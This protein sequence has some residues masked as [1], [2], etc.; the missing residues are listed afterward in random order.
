[1]LAVG[2][3]IFLSEIE[4]ET[5][6]LE[7]SISKTDRVKA[8][9]FFSISLLHSKLNLLLI[10]N[11]ISMK[12][13]YFYLMVLFIPVLFVCS[14][15]NNSNESDKNNA[16]QNVEKVNEFDLL[17]K[18]LGD[19][20]FIN[21]SKKEGGAPTMIKATQL[22]ELLESGANVL[23]LD[24]RNSFDYDAGHIKFAE[25]VAM[26]D[27]IDYA[28]EKDLNYYEKVVVVC[29]T[30]QSA[31]YATSVLRHLGYNNVYDLKWGMC[32]WGKKFAEKKWLANTSSKYEKDLV[33]DAAPKSAKGAYPIIETGKTNAD[34]ILE[35]QA[36]KLLA[37]GFGKA[38]IKVD[39]LFANL[40]KYY[41]INYWPEDKYKFA[42]IPGAIQYTPKK[43]LK[44][45]ADLS[46]LPTD[47]PIVVYCYTGQHASFVVAYLRILGYNARSL[48]YGANS[49]MNGI[50]KEKNWNAFTPEQIHEFSSKEIGSKTNTKDKKAVREQSGGC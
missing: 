19:G 27:L 17:I 11:L 32:S 47:K 1:M 8:I 38:A 29:Y 5:Y 2:L 20:K 7:L 4:R 31:G 39:T 48:V 23:V 13:M 16:A 35:Y 37:E 45:T 24:I 3:G 33:S 50:L 18:K 28:K 42:H 49:F 36:K 26:S 15:C 6:F 46:T 41:I 22:K 40:D 9:Y 44:T 14:S 21:S 25:N 12:K 34:S 10:Y 30:G 43:T